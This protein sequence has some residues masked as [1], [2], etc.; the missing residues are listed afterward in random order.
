MLIVSLL[1]V[2]EKEVNFIKKSFTTNCRLSALMTC[3]ESSEGKNKDYMVVYAR[4]REG[5][6]G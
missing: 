4:T 6:K 3:S 5:C 2:K 1:A